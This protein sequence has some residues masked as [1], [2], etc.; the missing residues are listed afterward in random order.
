MKRLL[1]LVIIL[2]ALIPAFYVNRWLQQII[3]PRRSFVQLML[4]ILTCFAFVFVYTFLLVWIITQV[5]PQAN[6]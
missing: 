1:I 2:L 6:R 5:F 4:Y 3:Q